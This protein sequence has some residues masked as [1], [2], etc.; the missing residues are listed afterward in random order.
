VSFEVCYGYDL[1]VCISC[2]NLL[3]VYSFIF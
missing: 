3:P 1:T 2:R